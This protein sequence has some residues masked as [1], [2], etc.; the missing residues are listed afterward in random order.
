M[1][2]QIIIN[3]LNEHYFDYNK[4][5]CIYMHGCFCPP[6]KGHLNG[7][8]DILKKINISKIKLFVNQIGGKRHGVDYETNYFIMK[9][10][11]EDCYND[12]DCKIFKNLDKNEILTKE[13][14]LNVDEIIILK[15]FEL[16]NNENVNEFKK[17]NKI[18]YEK[19]SN[20]YKKNITVYFGKRTIG[21]SASGFIKRLIK[22]KTEKNNKKENVEKCLNYIPNNVK[23]KNKKMI[24]NKLIKFY[25][26]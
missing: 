11:L 20:E 13:N 19:L 21:L 25:L 22:L 8:K 5:Y 15:G 3:E 23:L 1:I 26:H 7:L 10:Y 18:K 4:N 16:K 14:L 9:T 2:V 24:L 17:I 12:I 6:H